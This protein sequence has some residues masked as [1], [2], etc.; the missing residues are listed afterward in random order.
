MRGGLLNRVH[1]L[2]RECCKVNKK[3]IVL[4]LTSLSDKYCSLEKVSQSWKSSFSSAM[5]DLH[6]QQSDVKDDAIFF[7]FECLTYKL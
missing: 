6:K 1:T 7:D 3:L 4:N 5:L 2:D